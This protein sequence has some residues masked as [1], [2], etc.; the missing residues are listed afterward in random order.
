MSSQTRPDCSLARAARRWWQAGVTQHGFWPTL[1]SFFA[2]FGDFYVSARLQRR[3]R[4]GDVEYEWDYR[5]NSTS[6][7]I[8]FRD[9]LL[10]ILH[11]PYQATE[12]ALFHE[13]VSGLSIDYQQ[14]TF[15][16]LGPAKA[17]RCR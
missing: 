17:V 14:F 6:A 10:G 15:L 16:D 8:S 13:M 12:P 2:R 5:V 7:T 4:Y 11:S 1:E 9:R 3:R